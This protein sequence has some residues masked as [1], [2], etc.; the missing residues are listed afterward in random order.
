LPERGYR[1][2]PDKLE[3]DDLIVFRDVSEREFHLL[4]SDGFQ[5]P[6][7]DP[8]SVSFA[9]GSPLAIV[10]ACS[11]REDALANGAILVA[12]FDSLDGIEGIA[13]EH[14]MIHVYKLERM[15][16]IIGH[17]IVPADYEHV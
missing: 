15:P 8:Q 1:V 13:V 6:E 14:S 5:I 4:L 3:N 17:C 2:F 12:K 16:K 9:K 11:H 10:Y 7:T